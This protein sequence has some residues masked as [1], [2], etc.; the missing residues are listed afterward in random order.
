AHEVLERFAR[1][2]IAH[3]TREE[4]I[5]EMLDAALDALARE[6]YGKQPLPAVIV[7]IEQMRRRL[8]AFAHWQAAWARDGWEIRH[9]EAS[10]RQLVGDCA[11]EVDGRSMNVRGRIDR[12]DFNPQTG[13]W[14]L[15]DYKT[16]DR[17]R[18]PD[19]AHRSSAGAWIDLQLPLYRHF[20]APRLGASPRVGYITL[21]RSIREVKP[22]LAN[23]TDADF[24]S[25]IEQARAV[26]R[27][28][29]AERFWPPASIPPAF[30]EPFAAICHDHQFG[31][32]VAAA[33]EGEE[34][35]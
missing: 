3:A 16:G 34:S 22:R 17:G 30:S 8:W 10:V 21:P 25:A 7:Q 32:A 6:R 1:S 5:R 15:F 4:S 31:A 20:V 27:S 14:F 13:Q 9:S 19:E 18:E 2:D 26:V 29:W 35:A 12:I 28:I 24:E 11:L 33:A 23:W